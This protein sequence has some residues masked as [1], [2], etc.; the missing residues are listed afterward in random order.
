MSALDEKTKAERAL[1]DLQK[2]QGE[3]Q[4]LLEVWFA[5]SITFFFLSFWFACHFAT[6]V[7]TIDIFTFVHLNICCHLF[8][9]ANLDLK[10]YVACVCHCV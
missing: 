10:W 6:F 8:S 2:V 3:Q 1:K 7:S 9:S 4:V 5:E